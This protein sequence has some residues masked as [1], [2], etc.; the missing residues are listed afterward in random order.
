MFTATRPSLIPS[1]S[2]MRHQPMKPIWLLEDLTLLAAA[3]QLPRGPCAGQ[4]VV[5]IL[6]DSGMK[7]LSAELWG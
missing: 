4:T 7:D 5:T 6:N 3:M 1:V 2:R